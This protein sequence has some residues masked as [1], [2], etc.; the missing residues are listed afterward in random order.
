VMR[1]RGSR[2]RGCRRWRGGIGRGRGSRMGCIMGVARSRDRRRDNRRR[3]SNS[4][5]RRYRNNRAKT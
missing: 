4:N 2:S 5:R 3:D 1:I